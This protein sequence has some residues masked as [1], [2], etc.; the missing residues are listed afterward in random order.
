MPYRIVFP[1]VTKVPLAK[2]GRLVSSV[3]EKFRESITQLAT[4]LLMIQAEGDKAAAEAM[5][6][7]RG[8]VPPAMQALLDD[9][10]DIPVD[11]DPVFPHAGETL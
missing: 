3:A 7:A 11:I 6:A 2:D 9:M 10:S 4:E 1:V 8:T 5:K